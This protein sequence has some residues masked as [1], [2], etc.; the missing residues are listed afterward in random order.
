ME[1]EAAKI[2]WCGLAGTGPYSVP[3][4]YRFNL[5]RNILKVPCAILLR[6]LRQRTNLLLPALPLWRRRRAYSA[7][8]S[9]WIILFSRK[10]T[11]LTT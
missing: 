5:P 3:V 2:H 4:L 8:F 6:L 9:R 11:A 10:E 1:A 7:S